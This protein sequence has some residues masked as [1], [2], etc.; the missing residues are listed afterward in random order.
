[1]GKRRRYSRRGRRRYGRRYRKYYRR[2]RK[3]YKRFKRNV[4]HFKRSYSTAVEIGASAGFA[5]FYG[6]VATIAFNQLPNYTE[7][8]NL[9]DEY[10][11]N[12]ICF[13][14]AP[15]IRATNVTFADSNIGAAQKYTSNL[16]WYTPKFH[17]VRDYDDAGAPTAVTQLQ[18]YQ[19]YH[20][21]DFTRPIK[22]KC[23]PAVSVPV[24]KTGIAFGY[25]SKFKQWIDCAHPDVPYYCLKF[26]V[27]NINLNQRMFYSIEATFYFSCKDVR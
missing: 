21:R 7:F 10:R 20:T 6:G 22:V 8:T 11:I 24:Y 18:E 5:N 4:Y 14:F 17:W 13:K 2:S 1:M 12:C 9:Y 3:S 26:G 25:G 16:G 27:D 15:L 23:W 19:T